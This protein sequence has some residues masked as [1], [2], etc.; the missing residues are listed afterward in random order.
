MTTKRK[1]LSKRITPTSIYLGKTEER[2]FFEA[3]LDAIAHSF[4]L[5]RSQLIRAI[6]LRELVIQKPDSPTAA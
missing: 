2:K 3:E 4:G 1:N 6:A 5:N